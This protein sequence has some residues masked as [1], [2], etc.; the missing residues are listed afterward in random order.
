MGATRR[1]TQWQGRGALTLA[2]LGHIRAR[3]RRRT[4][5]AQPEQDGLR[6]E[7]PSFAS[8]RTV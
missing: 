5:A 1:C 8:L 4:Q 2:I 7:L 6:G 3:S